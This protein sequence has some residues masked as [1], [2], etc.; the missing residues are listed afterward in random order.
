[1]KTKIDKS[2][3]VKE[4]FSLEELYEYFK[5][6]YNNVYDE[7]TIRRLACLFYEYN[8]ELEIMDDIKVQHNTVYIGNDE[9]LI[10]TDEEANEEA[11]RYILDYLYETLEYK[12][13][14]DLFEFID[15]D[16]Y[17]E[18]IINN[19]SRGRWISHYDGIERD[20]LLNDTWYNIYR[21][22]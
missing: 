15:H 18:H 6:E 9:Y 21:I 14:E 2:K 11:K 22:N 5:Q 10:L 4:Y 17:A 1:M 16:K 7:E 20:V 3:K 19:E 8:F 13:L 12:G